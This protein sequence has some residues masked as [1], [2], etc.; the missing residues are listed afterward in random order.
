MLFVHY[1]FILAVM[2]SLIIAILFGLI[3]TFFAFQ[4]SAPVSITF[5]YFRFLDVPLY[6]VSIISLISGILMAWFIYAMQGVSHLMDMRRKNS[7]LLEAKKEINSL[8]NKVNDLEI[9]NARLHDGS[10]A[11]EEKDVSVLDKPS[12]F[13]RIFPNS[14]RH[15]SKQI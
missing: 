4:N 6:L 8:K 3:I 1:I 12:I 2:L 9:E 5:G 15:Y 14:K 13:E 10:E 7:A 11:L